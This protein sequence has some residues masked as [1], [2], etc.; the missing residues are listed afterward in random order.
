M[1]N[2]FMASYRIKL[3]PMRESLQDGRDG[4]GQPSTMNSPSEVCAGV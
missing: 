1:V 4:G 3:S 2:S